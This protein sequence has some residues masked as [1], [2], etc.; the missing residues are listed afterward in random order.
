[1]S[2]WIVKLGAI[3][4]PRKNI[5]AFILLSSL[6]MIAHGHVSLLGAGRWS[7][8]AHRCGSTSQ[9]E[10]DVHI[11]STSVAT[12]Q[13]DLACEVNSFKLSYYECY[14]CKELGILGFRVFEVIFWFGWLL[15]ELCCLNWF[16]GAMFRCYFAFCDAT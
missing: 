12:S 13:W 15:F 16:S 4:L 14:I 1:M 7:I 10:A 11:K 3:F 9:V 8:L 6:Q 5:T 2:S